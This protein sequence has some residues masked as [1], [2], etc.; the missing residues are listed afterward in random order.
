MTLSDLQGHLPIAS[1]FRW[2]FWHSYFAID[3]ISSDIAHHTVSVVAEVLV[4]DFLPYCKLA[5]VDLQF[6][7]SI[8]RPV[9]SS[10]KRSR[11]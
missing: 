1:L 11:S 2:N 9:V 10:C 8:R 4:S 6:L 7:S 3:D 5:C